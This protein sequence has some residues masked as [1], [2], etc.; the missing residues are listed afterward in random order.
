MSRSD[1]R[2]H[3]SLTICSIALEICSTDR[4]STT[5]AAPP[6]ISG[7]AVTFEVTTGVPQAIASKI[8][9]PNPS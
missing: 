6:A 1:W 3:V 2:Q 8:G 4:G 5:K 9:M 7:M